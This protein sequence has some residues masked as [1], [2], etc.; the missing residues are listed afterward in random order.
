M[1]FFDKFK[2]SWAFIL[3]VFALGIILLCISYID[4]ATLPWQQV[5]NGLRVA[6]Q[7]I[8]S[9]AVFLG[10]VKTLQY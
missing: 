7:T 8:L 5:K 6:G 9:S 10:I 2:K 3:L 4:N 1:A